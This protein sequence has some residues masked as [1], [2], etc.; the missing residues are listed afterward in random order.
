M[1]DYTSFGG[2]ARLVNSRGVMD[3]IAAIAL[4]GFGAGAEAE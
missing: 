1:V 2:E 3:T 4:S